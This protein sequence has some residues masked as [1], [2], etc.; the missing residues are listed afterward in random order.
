MDLGAIHP[1]D[2]S[3]HSSA[4]RELG[5][6]IALSWLAGKEND[7]PQLSSA[8]GGGVYSGPHSPTAAHKGASEVVVSWQTQAGAGGIAVDA[9]ASCS[10]VGQGQK[11]LPVYCTEASF[12]VQLPI[13]SP[14]GG[15]WVAA[16]VKSWSKIP[17]TV[18][19]AV[20]GSKRKK[21]TRVRYAYSDW[22]VTMVRNAQID[23]RSGCETALPARVFDVA[24]N[25]S[26]I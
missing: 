16:E 6:R 22:P 19:L 15:E 25:S 8:A 7:A 17:A 4:K 11:I 13:V 18:T 26:E 23:E 5:R 1:S 21:P 12:E 24:V 2:G 10:S 3:I 14:T 9:S 20:P